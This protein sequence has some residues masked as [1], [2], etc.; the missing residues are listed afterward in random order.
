MMVFIKR[1]DKGITCQFCCYCPAQGI[2]EKKNVEV[3]LCDKCA[4]LI[5]SQGEEPDDA[6]NN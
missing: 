6:D 2:W 4:D 5:I 1:A 3:A